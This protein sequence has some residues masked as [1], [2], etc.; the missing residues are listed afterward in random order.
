MARSL[1]SGKDLTD[2]VQ[3]G[4]DA[5]DVEDGLLLAGEGGVRQVLGR[6]RGAHRHGARQRRDGRAHLLRKALGQRRTGHQGPE[7][8]VLAG[9]QEP[10][11]AL[12]QRSD[13]GAVGVGGHA[14]AARHGQARGDELPEIRPLA[15]HA[16][17][18]GRPY[19][20]QV[21]NHADSLRRWG[22]AAARPRAAARL[23]VR[24]MAVRARPAPAPVTSHRLSA[25]TP[26]PA[27]A[28][29]PSWVSAPAWARR[30]SG[31]ADWASS[32]SSGNMR[33]MPV[34]AIMRAAATTTRWGSRASGR[35]QAASAQQV[36][37]TQQTAGPATSPEEPASPDKPDQPESPQEPDQPT[38]TP[39]ASSGAGVRRRFVIKALSV[40]I[41]AT[42]IGTL[43][44]AGTWWMT[45]RDGSKDDDQAA[46]G[47]FSMS[48]LEGAFLQGTR[49]TWSI[50]EGRATVALSPD[51]TQVVALCP[52]L[53]S[54]DFS[55]EPR[56][57]PVDA[58]ALGEPVV[59]PEDQM[60][61]NNGEYSVVLS[62]WARSPLIWDSV[63]D[64]SSSTSSL[65]P[66]D[67]AS[68][69]FLG[70]PS[71]S[72]AILLE[73]PHVFDE[74]PSTPPQGA[75]IA[76][77]KSGKE[78]WRTTDEYISGFFDPARPDLLIGY[79]N[80]GG[81][82]DS[83]SISVTPHL[84]DPK[85]GSMRV[86][87]SPVVFDDSGKKSGGLL[88][89]SDGLVC[90]SNDGSTMTAEA[91]AFDGQ[92]AWSLTGKFAKI[93]F[94]GVPSLD[95]VNQAL[96]S[97]DGST[98]LIAENGTALIQASDGGFSI[99][100]TGT[101]LKLGKYDA[102]NVGF[103][104]FSYFT[105]L[106]DG[107]GVLT[108]A[109]AKEESVRMLDTSTGTEAWSVPGQLVGDGLPQNQSTVKTLPRST[110]GVT[111]NGPLPAGIMLIAS[112]TGPSATITCFAPAS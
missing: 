57:Y 83:K 17:D 27:P 65:V 88:L 68:V 108:Q 74:T 35:Q 67:T 34:P 62:W 82:D 71:K 32:S 28:L 2:A 109:S 93:V 84:L 56:V 86:A 107:S 22:R 43:V 31:A 79:K 103:A 5:D 8:F 69:M 61:K 4:V 72:R 73:A 30:S 26:R 80:E 75:M 110:G 102:E 77:G 36:A 81:E 91:Y 94:C 97:Q 51:G 92:S 23:M 53:E 85:T 78:L 16:G 20:S 112:G 11:H 14:E 19:G 39:D 99:E 24:K 49:E 64:A 105:V 33:P 98:A 29:R 111:R 44:G 25:G 15:A 37:D 59:F 104:D 46:A 13:G 18:V 101:A 54:S 100:G 21:D 41:G 7:P 52:K 3:D 55:Y 87:L 40:G 58:D 47:P 63:Y 60:S 10:R 38:D 42:A 70:A 6:G 96:T 1:H 89:A 9:R 76:V 50:A 90:F 95:V 12:S 66:W 45:H 48:A 106:A